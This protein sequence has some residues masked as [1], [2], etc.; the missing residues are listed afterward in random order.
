MSWIFLAVAIA[1][2]VAGTAALERASRS[3]YRR[4]FSLAAAGYLLGIYAFARALQTLP[5]SVADAIFFAGAT[6]MITAFSVTWLGERLTTRKAV[7]LVLVVVGVVV[8]RLETA[9]G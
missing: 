4:Y 7:A 5:I 1:G 3:H 9:H 2:D 8:L 6:A